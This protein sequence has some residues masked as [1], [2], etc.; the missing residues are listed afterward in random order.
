VNAR[1]DLLS[2]CRID[3]LALRAKAQARARPAIMR[4]KTTRAAKRVAR[5]VHKNQ[6][7]HVANLACILKIADTNPDTL[8]SPRHL[9]PMPSRVAK[10]DLLDYYGTTV[11]PSQSPSGTI[12]TLRACLAAT[13]PRPSPHK[14]EWRIEHLVPL[15]DSH[16]CGEAM[17]SLMTT[18]IKGD[19]SHKIVDL[20]SSATLVILLKKTQ[21]QWQR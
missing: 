21:K 9:Y 5:L 2:R 4:S 17:A 12:D 16:A 19:V 11:Q 7:A 8:K 10:T 6:F 18:I 15:V 14:C 3:E 1:L 13:P 20:L